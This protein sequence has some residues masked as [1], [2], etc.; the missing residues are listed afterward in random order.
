MGSV[1]MADIVHVQPERM[2]DAVHEI[3]LERRVVPGPACLISDSL[4][5]A[6]VH[7]FL[8]HERLGFFLPVAAAACP[9]MAACMAARNT[10]STAL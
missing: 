9:G 10:R 4:E 1:V 2:A 3:L 6:Q 5:Q 7:Q 8:L